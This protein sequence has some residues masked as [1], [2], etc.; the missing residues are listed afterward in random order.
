MSRSLDDTILLLS[1][2]QREKMMMKAVSLLL[3]LASYVVIWSTTTITSSSA[4][5]DYMLNPEPDEPAALFITDE[6]TGI[7][8]V[9]TLFI[10]E[11]HLV[12]VTGLD[13]IVNEAATNV[14][15]TSGVL[16]WETIVDGLVM[17]QGTVALSEAGQLLPDS[18]DA[19]SFVVTS[20]GKH[21]VEVIL[22][23]DDDPATELIVGNEYVAYRSGVSIIPMILVLVMAMVTQL[24]RDRKTKV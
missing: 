22:R 10:D 17:A 18:L 12:T 19:G 14:T 11:V 24:V 6:A 23:I 1:I 7:E 2:A 15:S 21:T 13:W 4:S 20:N 9:I 16:A 8:G 3:P 5:F